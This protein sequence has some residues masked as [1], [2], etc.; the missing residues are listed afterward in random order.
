MVS[1][2]AS[3]E[4]WVHLGSI[5]TLKKLE[6]HSAI[7]AW[8]S[9]ARNFCFVIFLQWSWSCFIT[10][11]WN[12][13]PTYFPLTGVARE[14][15]V[16]HP[17]RSVLYSWMTLTCPLRKNMVPSPQL[18]CWD[19]CVACREY[20]LKVR[21]CRAHFCLFSVGLTI[22]IRASRTRNLVGWEKIPLNSNCS[23]GTAFI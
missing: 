10:N 3:F 6:L 20:V 1:V 11:F 22:A 5:E 15:T 13:M 8:D 2:R 14:C 19:R 21:K 4:V 23:P 17:E 7:A 9:Y 16:P 12:T 18:S